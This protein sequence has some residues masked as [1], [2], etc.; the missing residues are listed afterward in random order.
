MHSKNDIFNNQVALNYQLFNSLFLTLPY[1]GISSTGSF[2]PLLA[3]KCEQGLKQGATP[4]QIIHD[5]FEN[6]HAQLPQNQQIDML[7]KFIQYIER[8]VVLFDAVEDAAFEQLNDLQGKGTF[9]HFFSLL[10]NPNQKEAFLHKMKDFGV[11][12]VLT[13]HPTQFYTGHILGIITDLEQAIRE[14]NTAEVSFLLKQLGLTPMYRR[15]KPTPIDEAIALI[16]YLENIFYSVIGQ[17][18]SDLKQKFPDSDINPGLV[19]LGFWPG[20][21]RDGNP[22]VTAD[23]TLVTAEK[24]RESIIRA[25]LQEVRLLKRKLT[26][27]DTDRRIRIIE[28]KLQS[29]IYNHENAFYSN[30]AELLHDLQDIHTELIQNYQGI[31]ADSLIRLMDKVSIFGF[32]FAELD[33][34]QDSRVHRSIA[35]EI[36]EFRGLFQEYNLLQTMHDKLNFWRKIEAKKM[37]FNDFEGITHETLKLYHYLK[38]IRERNGSKACSRHIISNTRNEEDLFIL[39]FLMQSGGWD[40]PLPFDLI[41]LFETIDDLK[42]CGRVMKFLYQDADY[43]KQLAARNHKQT[44]MLGFSDGTK[45]GGY[46]AANWAI[47]QAKKQLT[48]I[49]R[50]HGVKVLFFDGR[51]GPPA[52]GGGD[53]HAYYAALGKDIENEEIQITI[54]GQTISSK[55]GNHHSARFNLEQLLTAG[56]NNHVFPRSEQDFTADEENLM[57]L[58]AQESLQ[59][60]LDLKNNPLFVKY[61][62]QKTVLNFY[63]ETNV[64]SRPAKRGKSSQLNLDDLRAIPFVGAWAQMKQNVPGYYGFGIALRNLMQKGYGDSIQNLYHN[65]LFFKALVYNSMQALAKTRFEITQH[66]KNDP[67][68]GSFYQTLKSEAEQS[69]KLLMQ[70]ANYHSLLQEAPN[71]LKSIHLREQIVLPLLIIQQY[72]LQNF[73]TTPEGSPENQ[74]WKKLVLRCFFGNINA[75]RNSA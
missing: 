42:D 11:R 63:G 13:A 75:S 6:H 12:V 71:N 28:K 66:L 41:P 56:L 17:L 22:F 35:Q 60:Y 53:T 21:D 58:L 18:Y 40:T 68:F 59:A 43:Q 65:S 48:H 61:L 24:L 52:R 62:E 45:D 49:S 47:Y 38:Q 29:S 2:L 25:Y 23:T 50:E 33:I 36:L 1:A 74:Q 34:R 37:D 39:Q 15:K 55:F 9:S 16:W 64:G 7:F 3:Q 51:G 14:G 72:A 54:Q 26:F 70:V 8:Q 44:I 67:E 57:Q 69:S 4:E 27:P 46:V 32:H 5:F 31:Y 30:P 19:T 20:G 10:N 73:H